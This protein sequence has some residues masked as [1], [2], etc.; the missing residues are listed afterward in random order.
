MRVRPGSVPFLIVAVALLCA[1]PAAGQQSVGTRAPDWVGSFA[2]DYDRLL[3][4]TG[5]APLSSRLI[6]PLDADRGVGAPD[7]VAQWAD[8]W[9]WRRPA[10]SD[11]A[12]QGFVV[13]LPELRSTYNSAIP[14]GMNDGSLWAGRGLSAS[15]TAGAGDVFSIGSARF[16]LR[17][18][19]TVTWSQ[20]ADFTLATLRASPPANASPFA[21]EW[22]SRS[23]D[24]P[25]R[26]GTGAL[27][28]VDWGQSEARVDWRALAVG[29]GTESM[30]WGPGIDNAVLMTNNAA[31]L[32][33]VFVGTG[34]PVDIWIGNLQAMYLAGRLYDS[35]F[36]RT[37]T[38]PNRDRRWLSA[39]VATLEPRGAPGLY[40]GG[41]RLFYEYIP[42]GGLGLGDFLDVLQPFQKA[43]LVTPQNPAGL[44]SADQMLSL[45]GRWVFPESQFEVYG[46]WAR[47]D[48]SWDGRDFV[49]EPD[50]ATGM[51]LGFQKAFRQATGFLR[52]RGELTSLAEGRTAEVRQG[53][54]WYA[55]SIVVQGY[56]QR[57][58]VVGAAIGP[59]SDMQRA[60]LEWYRPWGMFGMTLQR[61]RDNSDVYYTQYFDSTATKQGG[62]Y[63][64]HDVTVGGGVSG[65]AF[66]GPLAVSLAV[67]RQLEYNR[68]T[69]LRNDVHNLHL[70]LRA[71]WH[72]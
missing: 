43:K 7:S 11:S 51:L 2:D 60:A 19:P 55:H 31:G 1:A 56:T 27:H 6:R 49:L 14:N 71:E 61:V 54:S 47:N 63:Q 16:T 32:P 18:A 36:W 53:P 50:H 26:F 21:D 20:N 68:Y 33:H 4:L 42:G 9:R 8:P 66:V 30:W 58:Q 52:I 72:P 67:L 65:T 22:R 12:R 70:E 37:G 46:E 29:A 35:D 62:K 64:M 24:R 3:Q 28:T 48:H 45:F 39:A 15:A 57:G 25:Q 44:D 10:A 69:I 40:L 34:R 23:I 13:W 5:A 59:G 41:G 17:V 38:Q